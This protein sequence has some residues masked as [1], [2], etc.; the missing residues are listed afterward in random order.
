[1][2]RHIHK[3]CAK[4]EPQVELDS[5]EEKMLYMTLFKEHDKQMFH[6]VVMNSFHIFMCCISG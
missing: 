3:K 6:F 2:V 4:T 5:S 1:M